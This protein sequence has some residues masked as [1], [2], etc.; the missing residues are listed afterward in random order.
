[1]LNKETVMLLVIHDFHLLSKIIPSQ[2]HIFAKIYKYLSKK[3]N[4]TV[5]VSIKFLLLFVIVLLFLFSPSDDISSAHESGL[6][7]FNLISIPI[8]CS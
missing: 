7:N 8:I 1:M 4:S 5:V 3:F 6:Q 2:K